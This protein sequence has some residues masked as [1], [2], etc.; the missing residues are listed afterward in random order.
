[1]SGVSFFWSVI[2]GIIAGF[3]AGVLMRGKG[4]GCFINLLVGI[5]GSVL[6][7]WIFSLLQISVNKESRIGVLSMST[8]GAI[9]LLLIISF[10]KKEK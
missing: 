3:L 1:M 8:I 7:G 2:I 6:G 4:F 9:V 10:F 5:I